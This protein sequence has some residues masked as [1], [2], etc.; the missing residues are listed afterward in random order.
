M[1]S[2]D[3]L[4]QKEGI[5]SP[6]TPTQGDPCQA[7]REHVCYDH[8]AIIMNITTLSNTQSSL[9]AMLSNIKN[10]MRSSSLVAS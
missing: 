1:I 7:E 8:T 6:T 2:L 9:F 3:G 5:K 10:I 4:W